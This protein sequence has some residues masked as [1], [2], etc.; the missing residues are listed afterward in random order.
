MSD[1]SWYGFWGICFIYGTW[2][3]LGGLAAA[4]K[5][6]HNC[7]TICKAVDFLLR[8]QKDDGGWGESYLSCPNKE[9]VPLE[10]NR[11]NLV[12]TAWA[13][14]GLIHAGQAKID[15]KPL[16]RAA[17]LIINSQMEDGDFPQQET[18]GVFFKN[19]TLHYAAFRNI[20][21]LWALAEYRKTVS[22][23]SRTIM[24]PR[25]DDEPQI[26]HPGP[27]DESLLTR[28]R[29]HRSEDIWNGE[30]P[31]PL[32]CR[33]RTKEMA[34]IQ[35][36]DNRYWAWARLPFLCPRIEP[37]PG[38]DYGP[39]PYA[40]LAF[41]WVRVPSSKSRPSGMA[42]IHYREQLVRI[43]PDQIV[44]QP[45]EADFGH[46][47]DFCVAGRDTWTARTGEM[48]RDHDYYRWYRPVTRKYVDRNSAKLDISIESHL[49]LLEMLPISWEICS[50]IHFN[51]YSARFKLLG[52]CVAYGLMLFQSL[53]DVKIAAAVAE[54]TNLPFVTAENKF[55]AL[56][57]HD[58]FVETSGALNTIAASLMKIANDIRLLGRERSILLSVKLSPWSVLRLWE[59][60]WPSQ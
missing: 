8:T 53:F 26:L 41:K 22:L 13:M 30:D 10:G 51:A 42:L 40:P 34:S 44:W 35:M 38:C 12:Q 24:E 56:P 17:K 55:E 6:Y 31:G 5:T 23:P 25:I 15:P 4:G 58:A 50:A 57:A 48:P 29:Y 1:G 16:H 27:L 3:A 18:T 52:S 49:A 37:P 19:C 33:G 47:P 20:F 45:Y 43:Q 60:M 9:Y 21:P 14:M 36:G 59:T 2:F 46:L 39:W 32:T 11:S 28:Q 54:E 7:P